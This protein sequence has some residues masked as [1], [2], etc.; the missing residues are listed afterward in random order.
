MVSVPTKC[1]CVRNS[2]YCIICGWSAYTAQTF[3]H[4]IG[5]SGTTV[6]LFRFPVGNIFH[7]RNTCRSWQCSNRSGCRSYWWSWFTT[8]TTNTIALT[9]C[10]T[11]TTVSLRCI[12]EPLTIISIL[13]IFSWRWCR[14]LGGNCWFTTIT[15]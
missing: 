6:T 7:T 2:A 14:L 4:A 15:T 5:G 1:A 11:L 9:I 13:T 10:R 8:H 3:T 12:V